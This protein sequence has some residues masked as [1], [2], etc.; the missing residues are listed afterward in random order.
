MPP[1]QLAFHALCFCALKS[2]LNWPISPPAIILYLAIF[3]EQ[4]EGDPIIF[5]SMARALVT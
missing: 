4:E 2:I 3:S 5:R 1:T